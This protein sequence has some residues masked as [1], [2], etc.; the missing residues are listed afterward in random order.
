MPV[1][2][3][4][5][6][7]PLAS[8]SPWII[9][10]WHS[11]QIGSSHVWLEFGKLQPAAVDFDEILGLGRLQLLICS[12]RCFDGRARL[13]LSEGL[14][15]TYHPQSPPRRGLTLQ[16]LHLHT[17]FASPREPDCS[18]ISCSPTLGTCCTIV[19]RRRGCQ[20][21]VGQGHCIDEG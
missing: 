9:S 14:A 12:R 8:H 1:K 5:D 16:F 15:P 20:S 21:P 3:V 17:K 18:F 13:S 6:S 7:D 19:H 2:G 4:P 10:L 11:Y